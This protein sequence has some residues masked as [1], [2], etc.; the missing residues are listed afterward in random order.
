MKTK[1]EFSE[2]LDD[3]DTFDYF[4]KLIV[5]NFNGFISLESSNDFED[6]VKIIS[7]NDYLALGYP[8]K[9]IQAYHSYRCSHDFDCCGCISSQSLRIID[10][11]NGYVS[12]FL[13]TTYNY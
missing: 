6:R 13:R 5:S 11:K 9:N 7:K 1:R 3:E 12:I 4:L 10:N 2:F 8:L